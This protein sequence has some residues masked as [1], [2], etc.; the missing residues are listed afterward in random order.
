MRYTVRADTAGNKTNTAT[1]ITSD[2]IE[3]NNDVQVVIQI[4]L[5]C[6]S[7]YGNGTRLNCSAGTVYSGNDT[8]FLSSPGHFQS[9]CCVSG[10]LLLVWH[11]LSCRGSAKGFQGAVLVGPWFAMLPSVQ[12]KYAW[13]YKLGLDARHLSRRSLC[14]YDI[15]AQISHHI[16]REG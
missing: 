3:T 5:S 6:G 7:P 16:R 13:Q 1:L 8:D 9:V 4:A 2:S 10:V 14:G 12:A 11:Y 15:H